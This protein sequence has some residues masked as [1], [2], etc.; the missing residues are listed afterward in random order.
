MKTINSFLL[1]ISAFIIISFTSSMAV[2]NSS[3]H[4]NYDDNETDYDNG[5]TYDNSNNTYEDNTESEDTESND[6]KVEEENKYD[7]EE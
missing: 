3:L 7:R 1:L 6:S 2:A 4:N 5:D